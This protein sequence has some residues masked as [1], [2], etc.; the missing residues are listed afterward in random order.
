MAK[1]V[2]ETAALH[3]AASFQLLR[4]TSKLR[5]AKALKLVY[6]ESGKNLQ[7]ATNPAFYIYNIGD[8]QG[9][10]IVSGEDAT[11]TILG[12]ADE[13]SFQTDQMPQNINNWLNF[14]RQEIEA[15]RS[16]SAS[17][18]SELVST[19]VTGTTVVAPLL[20]TIKWNQTQPYNLL[21]P[22]DTK[23]KSRTLAGCVAIAM[24]QIMKYH[25][26]PLTGTGTHT[27]T[28]STYGVQSVDFSKTNYDWNNMLGTYGT[29]ATT[30]QIN[31]V[32][33]LVYHCGVAVNMAYSLTGS[34]S[35]NV[36][37]A[38]AF[39]NYFG[40]DTELQRYDRLYYSELEWETLIKKELNLSRPV[41]FTARNESG[42]H[43]FVCDGYD[44]NSMFHI[45]WGWGGYANGYFELSSLA[46]GNPGLVGATGGYCYDQ[47]I[48][49]NI[50]KA[51]GI[52]Q[53]TNQI[54][55]HNTPLTSSTK[56]VGNIATSSF[57]VSYNIL[58]YGTNS[59]NVK[60]GVGFVKNG[61][62]TLIKLVENPYYYSMGSNN[63]F[64]SDRSFSITNPTTLSTAGIYRLY[65]IYMPKD[66]LNWSIIRGTD[67]LSNC[68][69]VTVANNKSATI[70]S[71]SPNVALLLSD[72]LT[73]ISPLYQNKTVQVDLTIQ[74]S[75]KE[76][77]SYVRL[78][79]ISATDPANRTYICETRI[80]CLTGETKTFRLSGIVNDQ[81][82]NYILTAE[83]DSTNT[84]S[85]MSYKTFS[86][87]SNNAVN[88]AVLSSSGNT[89]LS[90]ANEPSKS[91]LYFLEDRGSRLFIK[92]TGQ[93]GTVKLFDFSGRL[94][95]QTFSETSIPVGDLFSGV[96]LLHLQINGKT[97]VERFIKH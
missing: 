50:H 36:D 43:A 12:Y 4:S 94:L 39:V 16:A 87:T 68:L 26:W 15:V 67:S 21:C 85:K 65:P 6:K 64:I 33:T 7:T 86:P 35:N 17:T 32:S 56:S 66:S 42:G 14:Y 80:C 82:G 79:L 30:Q 72:T 91:N 53:S 52:N 73:P 89:A 71:P 59:V 83:F 8:N 77:F 18:I 48:L 78:G 19:A 60:Y 58:N 29:S 23:T 74:N 20:G 1:P 54:V 92:T 61:S 81:P 51:D 9:F 41:F 45:N 40:Y 2:N 93:I 13:G 76:F 10:V 84:N 46:S 62:N 57:S 49:A 25:N 97:Y 90:S 69:I 24:A 22:L 28:D 55:I 3:L 96:Y 88:V 27:Y 37:A 5:S 44:S 70:L 34:S 95:R 47:S 75:G 31:A 11:K 38:K 63:Y